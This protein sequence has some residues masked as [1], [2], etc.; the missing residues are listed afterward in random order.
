MHALCFFV[1]PNGS[2]LDPNL[3]K[4]HIIAASSAAQTA[5]FFPFLSYFIYGLYQ[6]KAI[7]GEREKLYRKNK[8]LFEE[9]N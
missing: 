1:S 2:F 8:K 9:E 3:S 5:C 7:K 6:N 4:H